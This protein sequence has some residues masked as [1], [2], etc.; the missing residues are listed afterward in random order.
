MDYIAYKLIQQ[1]FTSVLLKYMNANKTYVRAV[2]RANHLKNGRQRDVY[3]NN[4]DY[5]NYNDNY[6]Q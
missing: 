3:H 1:I 6:I 5:D 4:Y 2:N